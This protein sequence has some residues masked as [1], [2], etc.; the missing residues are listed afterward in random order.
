MFDLAGDDNCLIRGRARVGSAE[1][2]VCTDGTCRFDGGAIFGVVPKTLWSKKMAADDQNRVMIGLNCILIRT[3]GKTVLIETGF[4]NKIAPKLKEIYKTEERLPASLAAAGVAPK[5]VDI[6]INTHLHWDHCGWNTIL[7]EDGV[8]RPYFVN[9]EYIVHAGE[10]EHGRKQHERDRISYVAANY[11][12][13]IATGQMRLIDGSTADV[14][15]GVSVECFPGHTRNML[16]V[17]I[18]SEGEHACFI[19]DLIPT[20]AH[21]DPGWVMS[22]DLDPLRTIQE[23]KR[24]YARAMEENWLVLFP[25]DHRVPIAYLQ[26]DER[27]GVKLAL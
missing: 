3:G 1:V 27:G 16:A 9:A 15:S 11:E 10:V 7:D 22:F 13:L 8:A 18:E 17:H 5:Q 25:H 4:G 21:L 20:T 19:S 2:T 14:C 6:V 12:P 26:R 24:F 23:R